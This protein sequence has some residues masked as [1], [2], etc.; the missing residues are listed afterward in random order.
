MN[1]ELYENDNQE[2]RE[3]VN[4]MRDMLSTALN[5]LASDHKDDY[6][7]INGRLDAISK[8]MEQFTNTLSSAMTHFIMPTRKMSKENPSSIL[9]ERVSFSPQRQEDPDL[10]SDTDED[11][12]RDDELLRNLRPV[13]LRNHWIPRHWII[14]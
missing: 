3:E 9:N 7:A 10:S 5:S 4:E 13:S 14:Y 2:L 1:A 12:M 6:D 8:N 11:D